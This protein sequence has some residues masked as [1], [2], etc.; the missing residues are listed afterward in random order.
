MPHAQDPP[1]F[2]YVITPQRQRRR[3]RWELWEGAV[4]RAAGW[5]VSAVR[6]QL[7][8]RVAASRHAHERLGLHPHPA[9]LRRHPAAPLAATVRVG[10]GAAACVL[11]PR[12]A[13]A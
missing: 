6:A 12:V 11:T 13:A 3:W 8:V 1:V 7:A 9:A 5:H 4:L 2:E 10:S